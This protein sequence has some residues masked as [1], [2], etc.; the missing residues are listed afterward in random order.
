M[1]LL[2]YGMHMEERSIDSEEGGI[3]G[4]EEQLELRVR[5]CRL[6]ELLGEWIWELVAR[7]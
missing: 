4:K 6:Q 1:E 3:V 7:T 2:E 5:N